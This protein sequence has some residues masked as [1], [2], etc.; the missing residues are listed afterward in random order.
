MPSLVHVDMVAHTGALLTQAERVLA[1][2]EARNMADFKASM[3][4]LYRVYQKINK[5]MDTM[6]GRSKPAGPFLVA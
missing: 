2:A 1:A 5:S 6:W 4:S 3:E